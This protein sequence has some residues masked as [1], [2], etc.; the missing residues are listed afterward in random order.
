MTPLK[1][2]LLGTTHLHPNAI[3]NRGPAVAAVGAVFSASAAFAAGTFTLANFAAFVAVNLVT[4]WALKALMPK[5]YLGTLS[6]GL[7]TNKLGAVEPHQ[8]VY[9]QVRKGGTITFYESTGTNNKYL[10]QVIA[11]AG[12]EVEEI[13]TIYIADEPVTLDANGFVTSAPWNSKIRIK[14]HLGADD[15]TADADLVAETSVDTNFRG[16]GIAYLYVRLEYD[17]NIFANGLPTVT[18]VVKGKKV[19]DP[20][21]STTAWTDNAALCIRDYLTDAR[22]LN[23]TAIDDTAFSVAANICDEAVALAAGGTEKRYAMNGAISA[24]NTIGDVLS[25]MMT[26]CAGTLWWGVGKWQLKVGAYTPP[27]KTF[28]LA[29][30]RGNISIQTRM[31]MRDNYNIIQGTFV[32]ANQDWITVDFPRLYSASFVAEDGGEEVPLDME[33]PL[34]TSAATVQR[35]AKMTLFRG[36]E[37]MTFNADFGLSAMEA[38]VGDIVAFTNER[39]GWVDKEFEVVGW[40]FYANQE[41]GDLRVNMTLRETSAAAFSW[42]AEESEIIGNNTNLPTWRDV[43]AIGIS[44]VARVQILN[45]KISNIIRVDITS[46][47]G[48]YIDYV[49]VQY[50]LSSDSDW[51]LLGSGPLGYYEAIDL[52]AEDYDFRARAINEFGYKGEWEYLANVSARGTPTPPEDVTTLTAEV[53]GTTIFLDWEPVPNLDLSYYTIRHAVETTGATWANSTTA[54]VKVARPASDVTVPARPGTYLV[55]AVDKYGLASENYTTSSVTQ[56]QIGTLA[57]IL[58]DDE[59]TTFAGTKTNCSVVSGELVITNDSVAPSQG[60]YDFTGYLDTGAVR[61]VR[62]RVDVTVRRKDDFAGLWDDLPGL[63]DELPGLFDDFTDAA[64]FADTNVLCYISVTN[65]DPAGTPTWSDY[66]QFRAGEFYGRAF[67]YRVVLKSEA[68]DVT[69]AIAALTARVEYD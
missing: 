60:T 67:R 27:V 11:L 54:V 45:E 7:Q 25:Y 19:F 69:P 40:R 58:T 62:S 55:R 1:K 26:S 39:Y 17:Q 46:A 48:V 13:G 21:T 56:D 50:K 36:R 42:T 28:G 9:G 31:A 5:P 4:S 44:A 52:E 61:R 53:N 2:F 16:R 64:Q 3:V 41:G 43:G 6:Q 68:A 32:D 35:L 37:Q 51:N 66:Q 8:Y 30:L 20:R 12:H 23:D 24:D 63:F 34:T 15:Q 65:D 14:K 57:N 38:Q 10:H 29:D 22:G 18:A 47:S 49:E 33:F 59:H